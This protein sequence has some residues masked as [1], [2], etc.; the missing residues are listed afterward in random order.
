MNSWEDLVIEVLK[1]S[2]DKGLNLE[3]Y[4]VPFHGTLPK[5]QELR[6]I[7]QEMQPFFAA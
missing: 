6:H 3:R 4:V 1:E 2:Y 7:F 5:R